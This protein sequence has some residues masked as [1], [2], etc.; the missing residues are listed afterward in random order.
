ML[1]TSLCIS[2]GC[3]VAK[4]TEDGHLR[5]STLFVPVQVAHSLGSSPAPECHHGV[6]RLPWAVAAATATVWPMVA[7]RCATLAP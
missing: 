2:E 7:I 3:R 1:I 6:R 5:A 4:L